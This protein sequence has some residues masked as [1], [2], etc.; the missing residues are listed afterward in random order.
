MRSGTPPDYD[1]SMNAKDSHS[2]KIITAT[3]DPVH[4]WVSQC[5]PNLKIFFL[6]G[7]EEQTQGPVHT[8]PDRMQPNTELKL[9]PVLALKYSLRVASK[10]LGTLKSYGIL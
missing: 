5:L 8:D 2:W 1:I 4:D 10:C 3:S 6:G 7:A 9:W